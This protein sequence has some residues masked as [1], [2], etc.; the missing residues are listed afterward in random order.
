MFT[1]ATPN[2]TRV[3]TR[4]LSGI[5][6]IPKFVPHV[7][8]I[9][10]SSLPKAHSKLSTEETFTE[11]FLSSPEVFCLGFREVVFSKISEL[12]VFRLIPPRFQEVFPENKRWN[13]FSFVPR[14]EFLP[15][16]STEFRD[17]VN[18]LT[19][20]RSPDDFIRF[21]ITTSLTFFF[22][23]FII[24]FRKWN[25]TFSDT[26][27]NRHQICPKTSFPIIGTAIIYRMQITLVKARPEEAV[28]PF[29]PQ[30]DYP[31]NRDSPLGINGGSLDD[32]PNRKI[33]DLRFNDKPLAIWTANAPADVG[34]YF[35][36]PPFLVGRNLPIN[37]P[38]AFR[39][40][41]RKGCANFAKASLMQ[42]RF[43]C[44]NG[45][46][47]SSMMGVV[48]AFFRAFPKHGIR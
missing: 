20:H 10:H 16:F 40:A 9:R 14:P 45:W 6:R 39:I 19:Q 2:A 31:K 3:C 47:R 1:K 11:D 42:R 7:L 13:S 22:S 46:R 27:M 5:S 25:M 15:L 30:W 34:N 18:D 44:G 12:F 38:V 4:K 48:M 33:T 23:F 21:V 41:G 29:I 8:G 35:A 37:R 36:N 28:S 24:P 32:F 17:N 43:T 26:E